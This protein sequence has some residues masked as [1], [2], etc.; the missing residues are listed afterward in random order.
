METG[1]KAKIKRKIDEKLYGKF[2]KLIFVSES[3]LESFKKTYKNNKAE[4]Q[5]IYNYIDSKSVLEKAQEPIENQF[6][7][8]SKNLLTVARLVPQKALERLIKVH[9]RLI[10]DGIKHNIYII[11]EGPEKENLE[12]LIKS[13]NCENTLKL[14]GAK[15]NPYP[16]MKKADYFCLL[17]YFEG[18]PM[19][20]EEAKIL[21]KEILITKTAAIEVIKKYSRSHIFEN[22]EEGI[23][24][25]IKPIIMSIRKNTNPRPLDIQPEL[26]DILVRN[27]MR[28]HI[29]GSSNRIFW[30]YTLTEPHKLIRKLIVNQLVQ[31]GV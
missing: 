24:K 1:L 23:Y 29:R 17:S 27:G 18:Y 11:G 7:Q 28:A 31:L 25:G 12:K 14:L 6:N 3:N 4:K 30:N 13:N 15:Q 16:Y 21:N 2:S 20:V 5:V 8:N 10:E 19:V 9:S 26:Q 22:S